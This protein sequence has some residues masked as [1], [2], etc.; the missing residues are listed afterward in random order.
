MPGIYVVGTSS[1]RTTFVVNPANRLESDVRHTSGVT[2]PPPTDAQRTHAPA[3]VPLQSLLIG[4][5]AA[6]LV[7]EW[8]VTRRTRA[9]GWS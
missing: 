6:L 9:A 7:T 1:D 2:I 3:T 5:A 4:L 8:H